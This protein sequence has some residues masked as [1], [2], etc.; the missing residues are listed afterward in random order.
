MPKHF[1]TESYQDLFQFP[2]F[3]EC[4]EVFFHT[5]WNSFLHLLQ[6]YNEEIS[7]LFAMGFDGKKGRVVHL[8][9]PITE[10]S[11]MCTTKLP[12]EG[13]R[14]HKHW[15]V[16]R[17]SHKFSLKPEFRHV[18]GVKGFHRG[19]IKPQYLNPLTVIIH[20]ITCEGKFSVF[21]SY[22]LHLLSHFVDKKYLN[23]PFFF[24]RSL[25]KMSNQVTKNI[26]N[27]KGSLYHHSLIKILILDQIKEHNQP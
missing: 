3:K 17:E 2:K 20:L 13:D 12:R 5:S 18:T 16:S 22:H 15:F 6:G 9:F 10:E 19:W 24:L 23:F 11:I 7:L 8:V 21:K 14:W 25:E 1:E 26:V 27:P 4:R